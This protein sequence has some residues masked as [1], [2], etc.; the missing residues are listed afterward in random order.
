MSNFDDFYR[1]LS[2]LV[3]RFDQIQLDVRGDVNS[4]AVRIFGPRSTAL[5]RAKGGLDDIVE[6]PTITAEHH[7]YWGLLWQCCQI[8]SVVLNM[9]E[10]DASADNV[11]E[12]EWSIR[13]L[14]NMCKRLREGVSDSGA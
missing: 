8:Y 7:P 10:E 6:L 3:N 1:E 11:A 2:D 5:S 9:W 12:I 14:D 4:D 13:E